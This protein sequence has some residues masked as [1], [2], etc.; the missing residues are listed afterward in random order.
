MLS[1]PGPVET[2]MMKSIPQDRR[3]R[4]KAATISQRFCSA[5]EVEETVCWFA[6]DVPASINGEI[7]DLSNGTNY[8]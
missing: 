2:E 4:L 3:D 1:G 5:E 7:I 6:T 8:R